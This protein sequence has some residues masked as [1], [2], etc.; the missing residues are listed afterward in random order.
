MVPLALLVACSGGGSDGPSGVLTTLPEVSLPPETLDAA[1]FV[2]AVTHTHFPL[3]PGTTWR[4]EVTGDAE[5]TIVVTV[6]EERRDI[7]GISATVV[8]DVVTD[9]DGATIED[10]YDWYAQDVDG[11]VWYLGEDT[12]AFEDGSSSK[13][14]SWEA[15]VDGARAGIVMPAEPEVGMAYQQEY[16]AGEA[17]D[18]AEVMEVGFSMAIGLGEYDDVVVTNDFT[19]LEPEVLE[20]KYYAPG[21]GLIFEESLATGVEDVELI[22]IERLLMN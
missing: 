18:Q 8:H 3:D 1:D 16:L 12:T 13:E 10:T 17:E 14:G 5:E 7:Q 9:A 11:N 19:P 2:D 6:L 22:S 15:G 21:V 4:Y 20:R